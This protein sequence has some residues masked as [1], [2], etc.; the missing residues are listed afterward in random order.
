MTK[1][2]TLK[3][4]KSINSKEDELLFDEQGEINPKGKN[5][6]NRI[7][8]KN[9]Q[10]NAQSQKDAIRQIL[11]LFRSIEEN[12]SS[13][14]KKE[15]P[16]DSKEKEEIL[17]SALRDPSGKGCEIIGDEVGIVVDA[18]LDYEN[19]TRKVLKVH[20]LGEEEEFRIPKD[21]SKTGL[22]TESNG[23]TIKKIKDS[24]YIFPK[25]TTLISLPTVDTLNITKL[26]YQSLDKTYD[27]VRNQ[28]GT[29]E[30]RILFDLFDTASHE[31]K[32]PVISDKYDI[33]FFE[34]VRYEIEQHRIVC[35][36]IIINKCNL[37]DIVKNM[38]HYVDME[39]ERELILSGCIGFMFGTALWTSSAFGSTELVPPGTIYGCA[40]QDFV[41]KLGKRKKISGVPFSKYYREGEI[42]ADWKF[43]ETVSFGIPDTNRISKGIL[44][45]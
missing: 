1:K 7:F 23:N 33:D 24:N 27:T 5:S 13:K 3:T 38:P 25:D 42:V 21:Q 28:L 36:S 12:K 41:G 8:D 26:S 6:K 4:K 9:G 30:D 29:Q 15:K 16:I 35:E 17:L 10:L 22:I 34:N 40:G 43:Q 31:N 39:V 32:S 11:Q 2:K 18:I 19:F 20:E 44:K 45:K 14:K 37:S